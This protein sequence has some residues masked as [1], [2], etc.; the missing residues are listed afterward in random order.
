MQKK[1][2]P[3]DAAGVVGQ[4]QVETE[5]EFVAFVGIDWA[6]EEHVWCWQKNGEIKREKGVL[7]AKAGAVE[8]WIGELARRWQRTNCGG[9]GADA[10]GTAVA[11]EQV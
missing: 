8:A 11:A 4:N 2:R 9:P 1:G 5:L 6:D 3:S 10:G 7:A